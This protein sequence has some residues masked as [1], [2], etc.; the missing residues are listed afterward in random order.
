MFF[1]TDI[2]IIMNNNADAI[3]AV[4]PFTPHP[5][6]IEAIT[7]VST[8]PVLAGVGG[9]TTQAPTFLASIGL[10]LRNLMVV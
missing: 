1:I 3:M 6:I 9:G 8:I 5:A 10:F 7:S 4:Y 2:A